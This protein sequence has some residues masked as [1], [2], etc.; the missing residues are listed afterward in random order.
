MKMIEII[1]RIICAVIPILWLFSY[2]MYLK[3][4]HLEK[5]CGSLSIVLIFIGIAWCI[6]RAL[7]I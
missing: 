3:Y 7:D 4:N 6:V 1:F 5:M 2:W